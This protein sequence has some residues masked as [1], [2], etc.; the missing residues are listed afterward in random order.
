MLLLLPHPVQIEASL[1]IHQFLFALVIGVDYP[2]TG[3]FNALLGGSSVVNVGKWVTL[4][5][6]AN[7]DTQ[8]RPLQLRNL[9]TQLQL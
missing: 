4:R 9:L 3:G 5:E 6:C 2:I 8:K 1:P 7:L